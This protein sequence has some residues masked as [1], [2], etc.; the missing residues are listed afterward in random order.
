[1]DFSIKI[2]GHR[3][4][5]CTDSEF[6]AARNGKAKIPLENTLLSFSSALP[7][8][9]YIEF[10][11]IPTADSR[12]VI[13]HST[14]FTQHVQPRYRS[15]NQSFIADKTVDEVRALKLG[16]IGKGRVPSLQDL[17]GLVKAEVAL[18]VVKQNKGMILNPEIKDVQGTICKRRK[19]P[20]LSELTIIEFKEADVPLDIAR[21][22]SFSLDSLAEMEAASGGIAK[23]GMLFDLPKS[24]GGDAGK[25]MFVDSQERYLSFT[26]RNIETAVRQLP[27]L[28]ALHPEIQSLTRQTVKIAADRGLTIATWGWLELSPL[29]DRGFA[30]ATMHAID[31]CK[32]Y[33]VPLE[34]I[35]DH[36]RD[37]RAF[38]SGH[39]KGLIPNAPKNG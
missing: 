24:K 27:N 35:T 16:K 2:A 29:K 32:S 3:G 1:M 22:S 12:I 30:N 17:L 11:L 20:N 19:S 28:E 33:N 25:T 10:D 37:M 7:L 21:F 31:L 38:I 13:T 6:A 8:V 5:G 26:P 4:M 18:D 39:C 34:I 23:V 14:D 36:A 9:N 15:E